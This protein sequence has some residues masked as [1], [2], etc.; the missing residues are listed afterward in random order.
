MSHGCRQCW[1]WRVPLRILDLLIEQHKQKRD[2]LMSLV[3][4]SLSEHCIC[5]QCVGVS[6]KG[7]YA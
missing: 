2:V 7:G 4:L 3:L 5:V 1:C 6:G